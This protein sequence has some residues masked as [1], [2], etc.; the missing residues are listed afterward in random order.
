MKEYNPIQFLAYLVKQ[1]QDNSLQLNARKFNKEL[2]KIHDS[3]WKQHFHIG[4]GF[5]EFVRKCSTIFEEW[6]YFDNE[7]IN[8]NIKVDDEFIKVLNDYIKIFVIPNYEL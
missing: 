6:I 3:I 4:F 7:K 2:D 8:L 1:R 5:R